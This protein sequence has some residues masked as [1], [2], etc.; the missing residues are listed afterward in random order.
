M[1]KKVTQEDVSAVIADEYYLNVAAAIE[2]LDWTVTPSA[3]LER[4]TMCVL[5]LRNGFVV[6]GF[7]ACADPAAFDEEIGRLMARKDAES[8]VWPLLGY[9]LRE[10]IYNETTK[11][12]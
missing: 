10:S 5:V 2:A 7:S 3:S 11:G 8:K 4:L 9:S 12:N 1:C 6:Q